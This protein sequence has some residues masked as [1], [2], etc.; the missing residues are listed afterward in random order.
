MASTWM[1]PTW[2][3]V[4]RQLWLLRCSA[5]LLLNQKLLGA[6]EES[7]QERELGTATAMSLLTDSLI[8]AFLGLK[9]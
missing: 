7:Q 4:L 3:A 9:P 8:A 5:A 1:E 6:A 2:A